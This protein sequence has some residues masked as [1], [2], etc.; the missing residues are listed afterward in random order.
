MK[1]QLSH[2]VI[3]LYL[4]YLFVSC[5]VQFLLFAINFPFQ[6]TF[7]QNGSARLES[8]N[9]IKCTIECHTWFLYFFLTACQIIIELIEHVD[10]E[11]R[12]WSSY[13]WTRKHP[14]QQRILL[15]QHPFICK[16]INRIFDK[17]IEFKY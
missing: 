3:K 5:S 1:V 2:A 13:C 14:L 6:G 15:V 7:F 8:A 9:C 16:L 4:G 17:H 12:R 10:L 11:K